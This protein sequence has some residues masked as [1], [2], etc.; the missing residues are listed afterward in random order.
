MCP[1][2]LLSFGCLAVT[3]SINL[4]DGADGFATT[5]GIVMSISL[6]MMAL[7]HPQ[8]RLFD[9]VIVMAL[10][11]G[12]FGFLRYN[13]PPARVFLGD[14][15]SML[16]GFVLAAISI[17]CALKQ[18]TSYAFFAPLALVA[19]PFFGYVCGNHSPKVDWTQYLCR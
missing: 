6:G 16:I 13:F 4:L 12:L 5:I 9:A 17:R 19:I 3:N 7:F 14:A 1:S 18:A 2:S 8:G 15:G 10:A 11:G